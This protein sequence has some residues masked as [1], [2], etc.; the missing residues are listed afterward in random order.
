MDVLRR[1]RV[2]LALCNVEVSSWHEIP[3]F[4]ISD[5]LAP[6]HSGVCKCCQ[7]DMDAQAVQQEGVEGDVRIVAK[8]SE[9]NHMDPCFRFPYDDFQELFDGATMV[10]GMLVAL[11][12]MQVHSLSCYSTGLRMLHRNVIAFPQDL[13][14]FVAR[15]GLGRGYLVTDR[16]NL[17]R[18]LGRDLEHR[19]L[20]AWEVDAPMKADHVV[21][22]SGDLVYPA[23]VKA[24]DHGALVRLFWLQ[25]VLGDSLEHQCTLSLYYMTCTDYS[26]HVYMF[27]CT[28]GS[29]AFFFVR[30]FFVQDNLDSSCPC[31]GD[32]DQLRRA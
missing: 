18:G 2:G 10:E 20:M 25:T 8:R 6:H 30:C 1:G 13:S 27:H 7:N 28:M 5:D 32:A 31:G 11:E 23:E 29:W 16:V 17:S 26:T 4:E 15:H 21:T 12:H 3:D 24:V 9:L 14:A 22:A 19:P